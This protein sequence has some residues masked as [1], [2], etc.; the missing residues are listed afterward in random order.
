VSQYKKSDLDFSQKTK[1]HLQLGS[2]SVA[3][4]ASLALA[5]SLL[6][7]LDSKTRL[8]LS[9]MVGMTF[10]LL[11]P[12]STHLDNR[13]LIGW[14]SGVLSFLLFVVLMMCSATPQKTRYRAQ[15]QEA[16]HLAV[17]FLVFLLLA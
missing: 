11:L 8:G 9:I 17:F 1:P 15:R 16:Q 13:I 4:K 5:N 6:R 2:V 14:I 10:Y 3:L 12:D 7:H